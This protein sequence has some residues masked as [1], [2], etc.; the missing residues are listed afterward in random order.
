MDQPGGLPPKPRVSELRETQG[1]VSPGAH[2]VVTRACYAQSLRQGDW[3]K[4]GEKAVYTF[5]P[6]EEQV[7]VEA[8]KTGHR[9]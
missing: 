7:L 4:S 9:D 6:G 2:C 8:E 5:R 1:R 3:D